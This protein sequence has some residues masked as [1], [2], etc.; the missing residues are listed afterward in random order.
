MYLI[1]H[2]IQ[3]FLQTFSLENLSKVLLCTF[4]ICQLKLTRLSFKVGPGSRYGAGS[5][6]NMEPDPDR[7]QN[8][9]SD[10]DWHQNFADPQHWLEFST[11][12]ILRLPNFVK[13][14]LVKKSEIICF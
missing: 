10:A 7:H 8:R 9:N 4:K 3:T 2:R 11:T 12:H 5:G 1:P 13:R 6:S 14:N